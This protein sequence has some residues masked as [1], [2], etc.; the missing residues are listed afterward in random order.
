MGAAFS[1]FEVRE[2]LEEMGKEALLKE[3]P[4]YNR[5][6]QEFYYK[7]ILEIENEKMEQYMVSL[8]EEANK[9]ASSANRKSAWAIGVSIIAFIISAGATIFAATIGQ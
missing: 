3:I 4:S 1:P 9:L 6:A 2:K 5:P 8:Q 7:T